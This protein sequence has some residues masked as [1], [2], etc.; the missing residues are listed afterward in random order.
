LHWTWWLLLFFLGAN[1]FISYTFMAMALKCTEAS[2]V[3]IIIIMN[4]IITFITM[5][6]L[7]R[8]NVSWIAHERFTVMT[9]L[10]ASLVITGAI[11]VVRKS[12]QKLKV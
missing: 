12:K 8:M 3:S 11:L 4:P 7:T 10:G 5:G 1:T 9:I 2:K 6:I